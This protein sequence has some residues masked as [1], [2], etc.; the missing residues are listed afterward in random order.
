MRFIWSKNQD[1]SQFIFFKKANALQIIFITVSRFNKNHLSF[2]KLPKLNMTNSYHI[3]LVDIYWTWYGMWT[4]LNNSPWS[5]PLRILWHFGRYKIVAFSHLNSINKFTSC[6]Q[7]PTETV[8]CS[9]ILNK[10]ICMHN[11]KSSYCGLYYHQK[12]FCFKHTNMKLV[13]LLI[14]QLCCTWSLK[15]IMMVVSTKLAI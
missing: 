6:G 1:G 15:A 10:C 7:K 8:S 12:Q 2:G 11:R 14:A 4:Y 13:E 3:V 9:K 5:R